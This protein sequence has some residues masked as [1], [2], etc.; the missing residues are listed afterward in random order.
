MVTTNGHGLP[1]IKIDNSHVKIS[2]SEEAATLMDLIFTSVGL[3][4]N[5]NMIYKEA[6]NRCRDD[7]MCNYYLGGLPSLLNQLS[8]DH[9]KHEDGTAYA[10]LKMEEIIEG[11]NENF[12]RELL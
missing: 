7:L 10:E 8:S 6:Y 2:G 3:E 1:E 11:K 5:F 9:L 12:H 4:F